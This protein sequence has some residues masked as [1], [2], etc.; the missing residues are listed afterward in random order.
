M[1]RHHTFDPAT[2]ANILRFGRSFHAL[3]PWRHEAFDPEA[4]LAFLASLDA[5]E[6]GYF[7]CTEF[8]TVGGILTPLWFAPT[9][10]IGTELF[11]YSEAKGEGRKLR[12]D[13]EAWAKDHGAKWVQF[14][15][16]A[17]ANE[18]TVRRNMAR[19]GYDSAELPFRKRV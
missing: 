5:N 11:W 7:R 4:V 14:S 1:T 16:L 15:A 17:D 18:E 8:G 12:E 13:F 6:N 10:L 2:E 3:S 9:T 19:A